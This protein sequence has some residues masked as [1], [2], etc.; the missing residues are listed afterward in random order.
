MLFR[1]R[2]G[3]TRP[4][5]ARRRQH[6][7]RCKPLGSGPAAAGSLR[8]NDVDYLTL[9]RSNRSSL[10]QSAVAIRALEWRL[11]VELR[12]TCGFDTSWRWTLPLGLRDSR[13]GVTPPLM[14]AH[15]SCRTI[16]IPEHALLEK[17]TLI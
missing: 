9:N 13:R 4:A 10:P 15:D 8:F 11:R 2:A 14:L 1:H 7:K 6:K 16:S 12:H 3:V 5:T 17:E